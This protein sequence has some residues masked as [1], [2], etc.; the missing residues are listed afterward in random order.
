[1]S[2]CKFECHLPETVRRRSSAIW[3]T[4]TKCEQ[5]SLLSFDS[6]PHSA[7]YMRQWTGS[8]LIQI[9]AGRLFGAKPLNTWTNADSLSIGPLGTNLS[10]IRI[11]ILTFSFKETHLNLS[12]GE[13]A[14]ILSRRKW[15]NDKPVF[16]SW[17]WA[18]RFAKIHCDDAYHTKW[19]TDSWLSLTL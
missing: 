11:E 8:A 15:V 1:M 10:E 5:H 19:G 13:M 6:S 14:A 16:R 12:S 9:M 3:Y 17:L 4:I 7:A 18:N 2:L